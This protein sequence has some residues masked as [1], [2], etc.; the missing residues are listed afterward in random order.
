MKRISMIL[1]ITT[2][3]FFSSCNNSGDEKKEEKKG[4]DSSSVVAPVVPAAPAFS[5]FK[6]VI[7]QHQVKDFSKWEPAYLAHDS[8]RMAYGISQYR[9]GRGLEDSNKVI[10]IDKIT[11]VAKAK[12]FGASAG[13]KEAMKKGGVVGTPSMAIVEMVRQDDSPVE[14]MDRVIV[15]HKVKD[16]SAW[17]KVFD[18]EGKTTRASFGIVDRAVGRGVDDSNMVYIAFAI[19]D[20]AK[21][22]ARMNSPELKKLMT[23]GGVEGA[24]Q[25]FFFRRVDQKK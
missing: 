5:P 10:V 25:A 12:E 24:P 7:I 14:S 20:M 8:M 4:E 21:A 11:D 18:A 16:Y 22:K 9:L 23:D 15:S 3:A 2:I 6:V 17:L 13:L 1:A 19:T